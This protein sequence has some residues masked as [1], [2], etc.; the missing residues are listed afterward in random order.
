L[1]K[2]LIFILS[3]IDFSFS[4]C[5]C[6]YGRNVYTDQVCGVASSGENNTRVG[7]SDSQNPTFNCSYECF[8]YFTSKNPDFIVSRPFSPSTG[9]VF[10]KV[11]NT[12]SDLYS[13]DNSSILCPLGKKPQYGSFQTI[14]NGQSVTKN[15]CLPEHM[16][17][18]SCDYS[19][20]SDLSNPSCIQ[21]S[22]GYYE[23]SND[24][25]SYEVAEDTKCG[26]LGA[27]LQTPSI[28]VY[29]TDINDPSGRCGK[30]QK[31]PSICVPLG[32]SSGSGDSY[33]QYSSGVYVPYSDPM[34]GSSSASGGVSN[35]N[36]QGGTSSPT[37]G[38]SSSHSVGSSSPTG[39]GSSS[40]T[41]GGTSSGGTGTGTGTG[42]T[43]DGQGSSGVGSSGS[44]SEAEGLDDTTIVYDANGKFIFD[45]SK[46]GVDS[47]IATFLPQSPIANDVSCPSASVSFKT[48]PIDILIAELP[49]IEFDFCQIHT[50]YGFPMHPFTALG[51]VVLA[52]C[53][54]AFYRGFKGTSLSS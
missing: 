40:P 16:I 1:L 48:D 9:C 11:C 32:T 10:F 3:L 31:T 18:V 43:G 5:S 14:E 21:C 17:C 19:K 25:N 41:S 24:C 13:F 53:P 50:R 39:S 34:A 22:D 51:L 23:G 12:G 47:A 35:G 4:L 28:C 2:I 52:L 38:G 45:A 26:S 7:G 54:L 37:S 36:T 30:T 44:G 20:S 46:M 33:A 27:T 6:D 15:S 42:T 8:N 49:S 29:T